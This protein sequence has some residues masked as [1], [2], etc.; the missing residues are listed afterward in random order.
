MVAVLCGWH[1]RHKETIAC[2]ERMGKDGAQAVLAAHTLAETYSVL[3]R[4]PSP[5]RLSEGDALE[6]L[7]LNWSKAQIV[8]LSAT[9]YWAMLREC[10]DLGVSGGQVYDAL[11]AACAR[12]AKAG[13]LLTWN[14]D[15][16]LP[17]RG[18]DLRVTLP[19]S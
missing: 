3:T 7:R 18:M 5:F 1:E 10:R 13:V 4:L 17:F 11:I 2:M 9:E 15:H 19:A 14:T 16:F 6:L 12:K 8:S